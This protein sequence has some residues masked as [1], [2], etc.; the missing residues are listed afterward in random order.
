MAFHYSPKVVTNNLKMYLDPANIRSYA[1]TGNIIYDLSPVVGL[2][3]SFTLQA[4]WNSSNG[5]VFS[6]P[7]P[8][9]TTAS[10]ISSGVYQ[11]SS[12]EMTIDVWFK[13]T[14]SNNT[15]NMIW[16]YYLPYL[17]FRPNN[18]FYL[19]WRHDDIALNQRV[20]ESTNTY[21]NN[22]WYNV[23]CTIKSSVLENTSFAKIYVN[24]IL[25]STSPT[26][27]GVPQPYVSPV[28]TRFMLGNWS[29][30]GPEKHPFEGSISNFKLY[31]RILS[32]SEISQNYIALKS[33]FGL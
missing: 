8:I 12:L 18:K 33:R 1:S 7:D 23:C 4:S 28:G 13:R 11:N 24:G 26:Y 3:Y 27:I 14:K 9:T 30:G 19:S 21:S 6:F 10:M 25:E 32:D 31:D 15:Y 17:A 16:S 22:V 5:G 29:Y 2:T 20:L